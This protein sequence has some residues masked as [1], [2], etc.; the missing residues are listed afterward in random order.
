MG[1]QDGGKPSSSAGTTSCEKLKFTW[2]LS[3]PGGTDGKKGGREGEKRGH[4]REIF[5]ITLSGEYCCLYFKEEEPEIQ[6]HHVNS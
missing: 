5:T 1:N 4:Q 3:K 2:G 6:R